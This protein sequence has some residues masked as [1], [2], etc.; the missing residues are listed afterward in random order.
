[1]HLKLRARVVMK[2]LKLSFVGATIL[3]AV[4][5]ATPTGAQTGAPADKTDHFADGTT[6]LSFAIQACTENDYTYVAAFS[7][8]A[9]TSDLKNLGKGDISAGMKKYSESDDIQHLAQEWTDV[10]ATLHAPDRVVTDNVR[11]LADQS[12]S[13]LHSTDGVH[14]R[15]VSG[16]LSVLDADGRGCAARLALRPRPH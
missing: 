12:L 6:D 7:I 4:L 15:E 5:A 1:M 14:A 11:T 3:T 9:S 8:G 2:N 10:A 16:S 13:L